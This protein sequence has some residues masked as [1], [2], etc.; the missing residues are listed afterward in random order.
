VD[1]LRVESLLPDSTLAVAGVG[2]FRGAL[3]LVRAGG[4]LAVLNEVGLEDYVRGIAEVPSSW[5]MEALKAQ[6]IAART[7]ALHERGSPPPGAAEL[8]AHI[9]ATQA[10]QVYVGLAKERGEVG[11]R[12]VAAV[13]ATRGQV[14]TRRGAPIKAMY[15]SG[16]PIP[17]AAPAPPPAPKKAPAPPPPPPP[18]AAVTPPSIPTVAP[19]PKLPLLP[20]VPTA[21][22]PKPAPAS[23]PP[24]PAP[25]P[26]A[27]PARPAPPP[28]AAQVDAP[29]FR[30]HGMGMSQYGALNKASK[31]ASAK[32]IL[33]SYYKG[34]RV[35]HV[36]ADQLAST[37]RV[38]MEP[39]RSTMVV[40]S[41]KPFRFLDGSGKLVAVAGPGE[42]TVKSGPAGKVRVVP[43]AGQLEAPV[44]EALGVDAGGPSA[45]D[46]STVR[47]RLS[48][49]AMVAVV[50]HGPDGVPSPA[51]P[52]FM[53][54]G[55]WPLPP[56]ALPDAERR[57]V[58]VVADA[59]A[60]R[61]TT[62]PLNVAAGGPAV[63]ASS[64]SPAGASAAEPLRGAVAVA[65]MALL[66]WAA[67]A[68]GWLRCALV[69]RWAR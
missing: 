61:V 68:L 15:S 65:L 34:A 54:A 5:P 51:P 49:P 8:G 14:L 56:L 7:Y 2:E 4:G 42:W 38:A 6:A 69:T 3:E 66:L 13:N 53:D 64:S 24:P 57:V 47:L 31:G 44:V 39:V 11:D 35:T 50:V 9:C 63:P 23:A 48:A 46:A 36:G 41:A 25:A 27:E 33:A 29:R 19:P 40:N 17:G 43:P 28:A 58:S 45:D 59:G 52:V 1:R 22:A 10:C 67:V 55:E 30:G 21:P 37:I 26:A 20:L 12:W 16:E 62:V 18:P 60:G 32:G